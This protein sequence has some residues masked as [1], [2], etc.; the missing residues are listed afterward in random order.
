MVFF[1]FLKVRVSF[2]FWLAFLFYS[3]F[4][5]Q[6]THFDWVIVF[7]LLIVSLFIHEL[8]K[9]IVGSFLGIETE[10]MMT[11]LGGKIFVNEERNSVTFLKKIFIVFSG[12][13]V[14]VI[15]ALLSFIFLYKNG[16]FF[17]KIT[18]DIL[19]T[20]FVLNSFI[21]FINFMPIYPF[22][23]GLF[24]SYLLE[25]YLGLFGLKLATLISILFGLSLF[26][27]MSLHQIFF[28]GFIFLL[29]SYENIKIFFLQKKI[30]YEDIKPNIL[31]DFEEIKANVESNKISGIDIIEKLNELI[32]KIN[33]GVIFCSSHKL[34][35]RQYLSLEKYKEAYESLKKIE[36]QLDNEGLDLLHYCAFMNDDYE[37]TLELSE[38][39]FN[40]H[41]DYQ[42]A[43]FNS[44]AA[45]GL[46]KFNLALNWLSCAF[47]EGLPISNDIF[48]LEEFEGLKTHPIFLRFQ[49]KFI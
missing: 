45:A 19:S 1:N 21:V 33:K 9:G 22:D 31:K 5:N 18:L 2:T 30:T 42:I 44:I 10:I 20:L 47:R 23:F 12:L 28:L 36:I 14:N 32:S 26:I 15:I 41:N 27:F 34:L 16:D 8:S 24:I 25:K 49:Q 35:A 46:K 38:I 43:L 39:V 11:S 6:I 17:N 7:V 37:K 40:Y 48:S 13:F 29:F 4:V 3:F